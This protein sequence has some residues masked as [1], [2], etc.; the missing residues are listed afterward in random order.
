[1]EAEQHVGVECGGG[2]REGWSEAG[3]TDRK[4][5]AVILRVHWVGGGLVTSHGSLFDSSMIIMS[6]CVRD[7]QM[8][9]VR[10]GSECVLRS[11]V[12]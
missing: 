9:S 2:L 1:M 11:G 4:A 6:V 10:P 3:A 7:R 5:A 8:P 12:S